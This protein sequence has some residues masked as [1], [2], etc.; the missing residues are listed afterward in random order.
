MRKGGLFTI[1]NGVIYSKALIAY[2]IPTANSLVTYM[3]NKTLIA[4]SLP[5]NTSTYIYSLSLQNNID[6]SRQRN[7]LPILR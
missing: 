7:N 6:D 1:I 2:F 5:K 4:D 3:I